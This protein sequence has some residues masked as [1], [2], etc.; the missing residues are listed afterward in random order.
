MKNHCQRKWRKIVRFLQRLA[1]F[2]EVSRTVRIR[3]RGSPEHCALIIE[4][5]DGN[6]VLY[7]DNSYI[8]EKK[9]GTDSFLLPAYPPEA[10]TFRYIADPEKKS[11]IRAAALYLDEGVRETGRQR[12]LFYSAAVEVPAQTAGGKK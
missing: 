12:Y 1:Y 8:P 4:G 11:V 9:A 7:S 5:E 2:G 3:L 10:M 6:S